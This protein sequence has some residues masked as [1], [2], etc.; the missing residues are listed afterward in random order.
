MPPGAVPCTPPMGGV[1]TGN[2]LPVDQQA[3][4]YVGGDFTLLQG[5][6]L[7]GLLV[8]E[9]NATLGGSGLYNVGVVGVGS[10]IAP[11]K[12]SNMIVVGGELTVGPSRTVDVGHGLGGAVR[13]GGSILPAGQRFETNGAGVESGL[14]KSTALGSRT[15]V[16]ALLQ[17]RSAEYAGYETTGGM[18]FAD[19]GTLEF[20][21]DG[22]TAMQV[23]NVPGDFLGMVGSL[24][25]KNLN[26]EAIVVVNVLGDRAV[27]KLNSVLDADTGLVLDMSSVKFGAM[28]QRMVWNFP[29]ATEVTL[30]EWAQL[31][32]SVLVANPES[33][34]TMKVPG[35]NGRMWVAGDLI[36]DRVGSEFHA[37]PFLGDPKFGC[38]I[39]VE[40][41]LP[42]EEG[43]PG[44]GGEGGTPPGG[45]G[46]GDG[47]GGEPGDGVGEPGK[48]DSE[49]GG[50]NGGSE[51]PDSGDT[52]TGGNGGAE[53]GTSP[54]RAGSNSGADVGA[55]A[56]TGSL[57][58][59]PATG[60]GFA[61]LALGALSFAVVRTRK[62]AAE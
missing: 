16:G 20:T 56:A 50:G 57:D 35:T 52:P 58:L 43:G 48:G 21:G 14:G 11:E 36:Q 49:P 9:G 15:G 33:T 59:L 39:L 26:P 6:E 7:E 22:T 61:L 12:M 28:S 3:N 31:P 41:V 34:T 38:S 44:D 54:S 53:T 46:N 29:T 8:V 25:F 47:G 62:S 60:A 4:V 19:G 42:P 51:N 30:G 2:P 24:V 10:Q 40:E 37:F 5:A 45:N 27:T 55:L 18:A 17:E 23:F 13:V 1:A 32:G